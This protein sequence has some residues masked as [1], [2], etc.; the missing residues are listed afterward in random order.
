VKKNKKNQKFPIDDEV[1]NYG[2]KNTKF[3]K[4]ETKKSSTHET[5]KP[6]KRNQYSNVKNVS[7]KKIDAMFAEAY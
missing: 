4:S 2:E 1:E 5:K 3:K 6:K 7:Q